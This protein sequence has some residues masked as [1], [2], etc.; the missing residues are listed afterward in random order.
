MRKLPEDARSFPGRSPLLL[1]GLPG[2]RPPR[3]S[4]AELAAGGV[5][6][7]A[8]VS[9]AVGS[10]SGADAQ[11]RDALAPGRTRGSPLF[12]SDPVSPNQ[13]RL[14]RRTIDWD[15]GMSL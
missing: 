1:D 10:G 11:G 15:D 2:R 8:H 12:S 9:G 5:V 3:P 13:A 14:G 4:G 6:L 7:G